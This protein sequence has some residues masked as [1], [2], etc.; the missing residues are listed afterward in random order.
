MKLYSCHEWSQIP[1]PKTQEGAW[2]RN[3]FEPILKE[4]T[5]TFIGNVKSRLFI[6]HSG[7]FF[8]PVTVNDQEYY[9]SYVCSIYAYLLYAEE[10]MKRHRKKVLRRCLL[11]FFLLL[12]GLF[13]FVKINRVVI[14]NNFFLS[15]NLY[16][17][18]SPVEV[19]KISMFLQSAFPRHALLFRS[20]NNYKEKELIQSLEQL[21]YDLITS[22]SIYFFEP[23]QYQN[24]PAKNRWIIK[25]DQRILRKKEIEMINHSA[26]KIEDARR[27][28]ELY[29][30]LYLEKYSSFNPAF[31]VRFFEEAI[32]RKTLTLKGILYRGSLVGVI[33]F[34]TRK[35]IM[36][37]PL[38]GYDTKLPTSLGLYRLLTAFMIETSR[39]TATTFHMSAGVGHFKRQRGAF[40]QLEAMAVYSAHLPFYRRLLWK[41]LALLFNRIGSFML[42]KYKL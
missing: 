6:L 41:A 26:F 22:R 29:D 5:T 39:L 4:G 36:A 33:G 30:L 31:T 27:I 19:E 13:R 10:E 7:S 17:N 34:F 24:L 11:P 21:G 25:K 23:K 12:K 18:L 32:V 42:T 40:Q 35:Q 37:T 28:K 38:V 8:I 9:N 16:E 3:F 20:L 1:W 15:T 2:L 14:I